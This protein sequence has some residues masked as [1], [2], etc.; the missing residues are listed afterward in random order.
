MFYTNCLFFT[1][2]ETASTC[3]RE[4]SPAVLSKVELFHPPLCITVVTAETREPLWQIKRL[5]FPLLPSHC[6]HTTLSGTFYQ[7]FTAQECRCC[8]CWAF[9]C[10]RYTNVSTHSPLFFFLRFQNQQRETKGY[11]N[12]NRRITSRN[13]TFLSHKGSSKTQR[14]NI[15]RLG[16]NRHSKLSRDCPVAVYNHVPILNSCKQLQHT[17][18]AL[19]HEGKTA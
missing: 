7:T 1:G 4:I 3:E 15:R 16:E 10:S 8:Y 9:I 19:A 18:K 14:R 5:K 13:L 2:T 12:G 17:P 11:K 6:R